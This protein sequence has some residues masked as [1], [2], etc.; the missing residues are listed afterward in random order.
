MNLM[1]FLKLV[2]IGIE[3]VAAIVAVLSDEE[4]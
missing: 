1:N 3:T 4:D 2:V